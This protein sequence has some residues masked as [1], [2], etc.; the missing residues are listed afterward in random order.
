MPYDRTK[1]YG[2]TTR[3]INYKFVALGMIDLAGIRYPK[4]TSGSIFIAD[5]QNALEDSGWISN[6][7]P[8]SSDSD[9]DIYILSSLDVN[10]TMFKYRISPSNDFECIGMTHVMTDGW[11]SMNFGKVIIYVNPY[12][13]TRVSI[14]HIKYGYVSDY[15]L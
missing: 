2:I 15:V 11:L 4:L 5:L 12:I 3:I 8:E 13:R 9:I 10:D 14:S 1:K 7:S 6:F